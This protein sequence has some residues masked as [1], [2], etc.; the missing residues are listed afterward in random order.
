MET[1]LN[2]APLSCGGLYVWGKKTFIDQ[3]IGSRVLDGDLS[4]DVRSVQDR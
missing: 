4:G 3:W 1:K 2:P